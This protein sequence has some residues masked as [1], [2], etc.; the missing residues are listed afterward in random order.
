ML[1]MVVNLKLP[2]GILMLAAM[3]GV[4]C[5]GSADR[6]TEDAGS[7]PDYALP[8]AGVAAVEAWARPGMERGM[9]AIYMRIL[10]ADAQADTLVGVSGD[11]AELVE[12]HET[13]ETDEG[14]MGMRRI[15][16]LEIPARSSVVLRQGGLHVMLIQ[17]RQDLTAGDTAGVTLRFKRNG[18]V[19]VS[20]P[21]R[22]P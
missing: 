3:A 18:D 5:S 21:V 22:I 20:A 13:Y 2:L 7:S 1:R 6:S 15:D 8:D 16:S 12:I 9:S 11:A 10:N 19:P 4:S 17:L 14:L